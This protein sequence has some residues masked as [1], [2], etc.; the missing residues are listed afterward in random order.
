MNLPHPLLDR[1]EFLNYAS[2]G[3]AGL[4]LGREPDAEE[5]AAATELVHDHG[6]AS[7]CRALFNANEFLFVR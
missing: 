7:L 6:P 3:L 4:A 2:T 5:R 1:R